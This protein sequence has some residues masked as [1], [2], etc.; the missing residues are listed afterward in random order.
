MERK[1][2]PKSILLRVMLRSFLLQA[3]WNF[4]RLQNLGTL[5]VLKPALSFLYRD[6]EFKQ[7]CLRHLEHF[8]THPFLA[9]PI[10]GT[11]LAL[12]NEPA[13][14]FDVQEFKSMIAAP[15]AAMGDSFFWGGVR[16]LAACL[17]LFFAF[18]GSLAEVA[19]FLVLFNIPHL[20]F[21]TVGFWQGYSLGIDSVAKIQE[22][23]LP[24]Q[25]L[26]L[27]ELTV[28]LLGGLCAYLTF[29]TLQAKSLAAGW[30]ILV[31][32]LVF[33][34][35]WLARRRISVLLLALSMAA[36]VL[37]IPQIA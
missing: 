17:A 30:G 25:A 20:W 12:E 29:L 8:N 26:R 5:Y 14:R 32:P 24:D 3:S 36:V 2:I 27:K 7:A 33:V 31:L 28:I 4:E 10:F 16:P 6:D 15:Y 19:V 37:A 9:S 23:R 35:G 11:L 21:R 18:K 13:S 1:G 22:Q 34:V